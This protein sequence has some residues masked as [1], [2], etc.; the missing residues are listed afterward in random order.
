M[1]RLYP[2]GKLSLT[3]RASSGITGR[4]GGASQAGT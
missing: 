1:S 3:G 4:K 2:S